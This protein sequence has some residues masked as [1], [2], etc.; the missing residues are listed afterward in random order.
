MSILYIRLPSKAA[1]DSAPHW[2]ALACPFA[3]AQSG[4]A[5]EREGEAPLASLTDAIGRAQRVILLL[6]ASDVTLLRV[7]VPPVSAARLKALLPNLIEDQLMSDPAECVVVAGAQA[8]GLRTVAVVQRGW[9]DIL[10]KTFTAYGARNLAA[11]PAQLCLPHQADAA[12]V[13][14]GQQGEE[15]DLTLRLSEQD[16]I[17]LPIIPDSPASAAS[18]VLQT[19]GAVLP[20]QAVSLHV[21]QAAVPAYRAAVQAAGLEP[22]ISVFAD[23]WSH[24]I[25]AAQQTSLDLFKG[26]GSGAGQQFD[27]KPWRWPLALAACVLL[28]NVVG[29]NIEWLR[30]KRESDFL[31][32]SMI[33][34]YK[35]AFPKETVII[36]PIAQTRQKI[37]A[38]QR[39]SG[40][41]AADDF[42]V[43]AAKFGEAWERLA[44]PQPAGKSPVSALAGIEYRERSLFIRIKPEFDLPLSP[45]Q[46][47]LGAQGLA[48]SQPT[49]GTW[50]IRS[51]K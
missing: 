48:V 43:L 2:T 50:Q 13:A 46:T 37:A 17:G 32:Q 15:I 39:A 3:L 12:N 10:H 25:G 36:D 30:M 44:P 26:L 6:A 31:R 51:V 8:D 38:A 20:Q 4:G 40:Q 16:G 29:L 22:R 27:W 47:A 35:A 9:L 33:Q 24:W 42:G 5:V 14:V 7:Q 41:P 11:L 21:P 28:V 18:E 19:L 34:T 45:V 23:N 49:T 1:A